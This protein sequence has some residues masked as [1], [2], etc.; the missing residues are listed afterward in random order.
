MQDQVD[1]HL[2]KL[3]AHGLIDSPE[4]AGVYALDDEIFSNV[5]TVP[6]T[7]RALFAGLNISGLI[8]A[9][10]DTPRWS[11]ISLLARDACGPITPADSESLTFLHD[12][13][14]IDSMDLKSL[15]WAL[16]RRKGCI[17]RGLGVVSAGT[18][19]LEQAFVTYSSICFATFVKYFADILCSLPEAGPAAAFPPREELEACLELLGR[20][21]P[22]TKAQGLE[23]PSGDTDREIMGAMDRAGKAMVRSGLVDSSFGNISARRKG[24]VF[25]TQTGAALDELAGCIDRTAMDGSST[26]EITSSSELPSHVRIYELTDA[27]VILH[28]H[29]RF[30]VILSMADGTPQ[31]VEK[32]SVSGVPVVAGGIG[33]GEKGMVHT[34]PEAMAEGLA[35]VVAG[36]GVFAASRTGFREAFERMVSIE[37]GCYDACRQRL[38]EHLGAP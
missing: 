20:L 13:P 2:A 36:H 38:W 23:D 4:D 16:S 32:R 21:R 14:V 7:L 31:G 26:C 17:V 33:S 30:S 35:A 1:R 3:L 37:Q 6:G 12:I 15:K 27:R 8:V 19:C 9:R 18:V 28:G 10:P 25:I 22:Q 5:A 29:P 34:L 24:T 11:I